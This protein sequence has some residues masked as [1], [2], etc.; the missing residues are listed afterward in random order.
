MFRQAIEHGWQ[1]E[2]PDNWLRRR[3]PWEVARPDDRGGIKL[4]SSAEVREGALSPIAGRPSTLIGIPFD[5][6]VASSGKFS[7]DRTIE[8]ADDIWHVKPCP[9]S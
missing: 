2:Q 9:V 4:N 3:D 6:P 7:S 1:H 5:R 8:Y